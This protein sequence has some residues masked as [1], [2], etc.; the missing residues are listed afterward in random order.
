MQVLVTDF[1]P[2]PLIKLKLG[3]QSTW[4]TT[5]SNPLGAIKLSSQSE[6]GWNHKY[7]LSVF[8]RLFQALPGALK[9]T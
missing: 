4:D 5:T 7:D 2:T 9:E 8:I 1:S 6:I 3:L